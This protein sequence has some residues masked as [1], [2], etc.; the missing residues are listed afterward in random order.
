MNKEALFEAMNEIDEKYILEASDISSPQKNKRI[1]YFRNL[2]LIAAGLLLIVGIGLLAIPSHKNNLIAGDDVPNVNTP[3]VNTPSVSTPD[4]NTPETDTPNVQTP[5]VPSEYIAVEPTDS[6]SE[7]AKLDI[8]TGSFYETAMGFEGLMAYDV[9]E[10]MDESPWN[11]DISID[12]L[13]V[14]ENVYDAEG[15]GIITNPDLTEMTAVLYEISTRFGLTPVEADFEYSMGM[16]DDGTEIPYAISYSENG[17]T[18]ATESDLTTT[19]TFKPALT[20]PDQYNNTYKASFKDVT[21]ISD[22]FKSAYQHLLNMDSP[23]THIGSG[24]YDI[25]ASQFFTIH[26]YEDS[27]DFVTA[28]LNNTFYNVQFYQNTENSLDLIRFYRTDLSNL[29]GYYPI[30]TWQEAEQLL[31]NGNYITTVPIDFPGKEYIKKTELI[32]RNGH[33]ED[34]YMPYYRIL[35]ELPSMYQED[36]GLNTYG[37]YYVPAVKEEYLT[38]IPVWDGA[39]N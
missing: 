25:S 17:I 27:A 19:V 34:I 21:E 4:I 1:H 38:N 6:T 31:I 23:I 10:L 28:L 2:G 20:I 3:D 26:Y 8:D 36:T 29:I 37:A 16:T 32:Y 39:F 15:S 14:F 30:I 12:T 22:Y 35:V 9:S 11:K 5:T 18:L 33:M 7:L 24:D 13:P